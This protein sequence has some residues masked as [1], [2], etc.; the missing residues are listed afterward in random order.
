M[1]TS[2][3]HLYSRS[4]NQ[5]HSMEKLYLRSN[6]SSTLV[7]AILLRAAARGNNCSSFQIP[8]LFA[9]W[10][11]RIVKNCDRG[12]LHQLS[13]PK[14]F[15]RCEISCKDWSCAIQKQ[16]LYQSFQ[17]YLEIRL[18]YR[19]LSSL[20]EEIP[21]VCLTEILLPTATTREINSTAIDFFLLR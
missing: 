14:L 12:L 4:S 2:P 19:K 16:F 5:L 6:T 11:V 21:Q 17:K 10:E 15:S 8:M 13:S 20:R 18:F 9:G 7:R 1:I 3:F